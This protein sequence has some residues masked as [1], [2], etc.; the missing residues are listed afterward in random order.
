[1]AEETKPKA[2]KEKP[3]ALEDKPF[4][5]FMEQHFTPTLKESLTKQGLKDLEL[6]FTKAPVSIP[7]AISDEPCWQVIGIWNEG[8]R[9]FNLYF[10]EENIKGQKAFSYAVNGKSPSTIESFMI[11]E[12]KIT[13]DL[14]VLYTLQRLNGQKWLTRN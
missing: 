8:K 1:M 13:L 9:Q 7:G 14:M 3:P 2:K 6:S 11:D 10:P 5:E 12:R 4:T